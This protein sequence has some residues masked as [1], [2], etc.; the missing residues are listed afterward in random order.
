VGEL[1]SP[2]FITG[3]D[4]NRTVKDSL[5]AAIGKQR[6]RRRL[7]VTDLINPRHAFF[8]WTRPDIEPSPERLQRMLEGTGFHNLFGQGVS[9]EEFVEQFLEWEGIVGKVD[10][11]E[12]IPVELKTTG[13]IPSDVPGSRPGYIDQLGMYCTMAG[14]RRG[15]LLI[16]KRSAYG[17]EGELRAFDVTFRDPGR[18]AGEM[19]RRRDLLQNA[20]EK[21]DPDGLPCCEWVDRDC[22]YAGICGC[23]DAPPLSRVVPRGDA[24]V[25]ENPDVVKALAEK[26]RTFGEG[27]DAGF[28]L[29]DLVFPRKS[30]FERQADEAEED[31]TVEARLGA[32]Q[33]QGFNGALYQAIRFG[34]PGAFERVPV[35]LRS[36][37]G[38]VGTHLGR[39]TVLR[40]TKLREMVERDR[41][42][43]VL[44]HYF[45]RLAFECAL[46]GSPA[47][48]LVLYYETLAGEKFMV[49]DIWWKNLDRIRAEADRRLDL[50]ESG[51]PAAEL[52]AC[53]AWM[54]KFCK[55]APGC[56]CGD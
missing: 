47:G 18:I 36:L 55:F 48:R 6:A 51:A 41:L 32:I 16:Y 46:T 4:A 5:T 21:R 49:Y 29:N 23:R 27:P 8:R 33:K 22:D 30:A 12:T 42:P 31:S 25:T 1:F 24:E 3:I 20:I 13:S 53:P 43:Q 45:D 56:G 28:G 40:S 35:T 34:E 54:A 44:P 15:Q 2:Q 11:F 17:R 19:R 14:A 26:L 38:L 10:I 39:P 7:S 52:P 37:R 50:L 9:S